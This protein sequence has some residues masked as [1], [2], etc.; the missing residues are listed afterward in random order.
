MNLAD[1][2]VNDAGRQFAAGLLLLQADEPARGELYLRRAV[3]L[4]GGNVQYRLSLAQS[5]FMQGRVQDSI[6]TLE[7]AARLAPDDERVR[8]WLGE[9]RRAAA[10]TGVPP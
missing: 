6:A 3:S 10:G 7:A 9:M 5:H 4:D 2:V 8:Y 1:A